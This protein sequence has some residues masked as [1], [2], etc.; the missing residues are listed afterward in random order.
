MINFLLYFIIT[1]LIMYF[2]IM[3]TVNKLNKDPYKLTDKQREEIEELRQLI[4]YNF[5]T[6][7]DSILPI[8]Q[9]IGLLLGWILIPA[10]IILQILQLFGVKVDNFF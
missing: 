5:G 4:F 10:V 2:L 1:G 3:D 9:L 7:F 8:L 6:A